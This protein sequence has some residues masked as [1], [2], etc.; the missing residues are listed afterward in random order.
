MIVRHP[1][2]RLVSGFRNK[3]EPSLKEFSLHFPDYIKVDILE[4]H[5]TK[6]FEEWVTS[7]TKQELNVTFQEFVQYFVNT[8]LSQINP[9]INIT[10]S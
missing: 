3:I 4:K 7:D 5:R 9:H 10:G 6:E 2:E 8:D 1:L